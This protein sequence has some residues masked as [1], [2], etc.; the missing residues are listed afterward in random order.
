MK[1]SSIRI[2]ILSMVFSAMFLVISTGTKAEAQDGPE[3]NLGSELHLEPPGLLG[4]KS[5]PVDGKD[6]KGNHLRGV[7]LP[8]KEGLNAFIDC[9]PALYQD[10]L[11][12]KDARTNYRAVIGFHFSLR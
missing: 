10:G 7:I 5:Y 3:N 2:S 1:K 4:P 8:L 9:S 6:L 11:T 12:T